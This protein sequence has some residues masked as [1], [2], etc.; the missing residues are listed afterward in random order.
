MVLKVDDDAVE[1]IRDR[2][3]LGQA[4][5]YSGPNIKW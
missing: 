5:L 4:A 1:P 2:E 3:Q